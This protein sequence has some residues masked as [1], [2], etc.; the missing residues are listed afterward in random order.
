MADV[1]VEKNTYTVDPLHQWDIDQELKIYG[2]SLPSIP[3]IHFSNAAMG[4]AIVRQASMD[5]A[6]V[7]S[8]LIPNSLLQKPYTVV[9][10]VCIYEG[11]TF[12]SLYKIKIPV[13]GRPQPAD[14]TLKDDQEVYSF[15]AL[16][17]EVAN[18]L[19]ALDAAKA[20]MKN[21]N[22]AAVAEAKA[23]AEAAVAAH[24]ADKSNPHGVTAEQAGA[25]P[26]V[27]SADYPGCYYRV[28]NGITEWLNPPM[29]LGVEYRTTERCNGDTL[30]AQLIDF[31]ALPNAS[32]KQVTAP[33]STSNML[34]PSIDFGLSRAYN[35]NDGR[36]SAFPFRSGVSEICTNNGGIQITATKDMSKW[37]AWV[38][39]KY[40]KF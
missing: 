35:P 4:R 32:M 27:E 36:S 11:R 18:A 29:Q 19:V 7:V 23:E 1:R 3:E 25:A 39:I 24:A 12:Q 40:T 9:A 15:N 22:S 6:G 10:Y 2:L 17:N 21:A 33:V 5:S 8:V 13:K 38:C 20:E 16:E 26:A 30:Y 28:V 37:N 34:A 31:G 14:Y